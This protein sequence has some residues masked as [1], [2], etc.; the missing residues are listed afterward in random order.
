MRRHRYTDVC[1]LL[2]PQ[3]QLSSNVLN[4]IYRQV[5][6]HTERHTGRQTQREK[7]R[8]R[9]RKREKERE[10]ESKRE[11]RE[12]EMTDTIPSLT[13]PPRHHRRSA[14]SACSSARSFL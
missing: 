10:R 7:E 14:G 6:R 4:C 1:L 13:L 2:E 9:E 5:G 8:E 12:I 11:K 3:F